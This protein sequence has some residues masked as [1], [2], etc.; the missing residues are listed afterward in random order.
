VGNGKDNTVLEL[1]NA[2]N[3]IIGKNI[4][5]KFLPI[6]AGDVL[7]TCADISKIQQKLKYQPLVS[8]EEGLKHTV[9]YFKKKS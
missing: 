6:R 4:Q 1:V 9:E 7:R 8:F 5:P 3:R 2:L